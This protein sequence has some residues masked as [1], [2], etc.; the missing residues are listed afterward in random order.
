MSNDNTL[1]LVNLLIANISKLA[2]WGAMIAKS[3]A[4]GRDITDAELDALLAD[5]DDVAAQ[6]QAAIDARRS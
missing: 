5:D 1:L 2:Q 4:E 3:R 6:L